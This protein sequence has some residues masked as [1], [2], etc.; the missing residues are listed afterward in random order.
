MP[1]ARIWRKSME[2]CG[3]EAV[4]AREGC[5][6]WVTRRKLKKRW[7]ECAGRSAH[8]LLWI[9]S[10]MSAELARCTLAIFRPLVPT[11]LDI[12]A[13]PHNHPSLLHQSS[14]FLPLPVLGILCMSWLC[15]RVGDIFD[16]WSQLNEGSQ[17]NWPPFPH[18][19]STILLPSYDS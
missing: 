12:M 14:H 17:V 2:D 5:C 18:S 19:I 11:Y 9:F 7:W 10:V 3:Y 15:A 13:P 8:Y 1:R 16:K 4:G 6:G